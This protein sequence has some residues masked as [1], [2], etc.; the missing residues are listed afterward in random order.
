MTIGDSVTAL[1]NTPI[2]IECTVRGIP[3]PTITWMKDDQVLSVASG[4]V[5]YSNGTLVI[6]KTNL[7][8][9]GKYTCTAKNIEGEDSATSRVFVIGTC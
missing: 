9:K 1:T 3:E 5:I 2:S 6:E 8:D 7:D 4:H